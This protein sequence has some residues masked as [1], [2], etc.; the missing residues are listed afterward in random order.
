[1]KGIAAS[2]ILSCGDE[3]IANEYG[4]IDVKACSP[5][6]VKGGLFGG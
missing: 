3:S 2:F 4:G 6:V 5:V 1:M